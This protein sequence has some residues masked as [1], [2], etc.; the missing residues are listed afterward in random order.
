MVRETPPVSGAVAGPGAA[1]PG[2]ARRPARPVAEAESVLVLHYGRLVRLAYALLPATANRHRRV[3]AAHALVQ[4]SLPGGLPGLRP[5]AES[6]P[7]PP[8][9]R[10]PVDEPVR[11]AGADPVYRRLRQRV[12]AA[13]LRA[14]PRRLPPPPY[15][16]GLRLFTLSGGAGELALDRAL[17]GTTAPERAAYALLALERLSPAAAAPLLRAAGVRDPEAALGTAAVLLAAHPADAPNGARFD[18]ATVQARPTDLL[19]RRR[20]LRTAAGTAAAALVAA[21]ALTVPGG[22]PGVPAGADVE[23]TGTVTA[24]DLVRVPADAW[25]D[26]ARLD[27]TAWAARGDAT[28]DRALLTAALAAWTA[29]ARDGSVLL[30]ADPGAAAAAPGVPPRLLWAGHLDGAAVVL[31]DDGTR[32]ARY[33]RPDHPDA[34]DPVRL[35]LSRSD[36]SDVTSAG[37]VLLRSGPAG[38]RFLLA[39]WVATAQLRD[40]RAPN[41]PARGVS[42]AEGVTPALPAPPASGCGSWPVLQLRS[43]PVV[44]EHHAFLLTDLGGI[45]AAHLTYTPPP[46]RG[47][48]ES[49]REATGPDA[50]LTWARLVCTLPALRGQDV[51]QVNAW[52]FAQQPLP[53]HQGAADWVCTRADH[54][55]GTGSAA[56]LFLP[57]AAVG[58]PG[59]TTAVQPQGRACSRFQQSVLGWTWW[60]SPQGGHP[61]LLAAGSRRVTR[62]STGGTLPSGDAATPG[63][64]LTLA[65]TPRAGA[66][67]GARLDTGQQVRPL[68]QEAADN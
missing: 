33:T 60:R 25:Q 40:L 56:T 39:P 68:T 1:A 23:A 35:E 55:D 32:L 20:R 15:V 36:D 22:S 12:L 37:A 61:Y 17:A 50:L 24:A 2:G 44:A 54:W 8:P 63:H 49:P 59:L 38:D 21:L 27:F 62:I 31:F 26:T 51:K 57:P 45:T 42:A 67:L 52:Q 6:H 41:T 5:R 47:P 4:R 53:E 65:V 11:F 34:S 30:T 14:R 58:A 48:A 16:W 10:E 43:S 9:P 28:G 66:V 18:S 3:L 19:R 46:Q 13:G 7:A 29:P 64:T